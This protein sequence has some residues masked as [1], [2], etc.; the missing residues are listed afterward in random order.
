M[1]LIACVAVNAADFVTEGDGTTYTLESLSTN[2]ESGVTK[3]GP[4]YV[5]ANN[6]TIS[7]ND[8]FAIESGATVKMGDGV[9]LRI[10]GSANFEASDRVLFTRNAETDAPKG[11][12]LSDNT[13]VTKFKNID[14]EYCGLR[15][16]GTKGLDAD[17]CTF[18]Y[19]NGKQSSSGALALGTDGAC[20][21][22]TGC[23]F[24]HNTAPAIG[25]GANYT[26]GIRIENCTFTD[27]NNSNTNKPQLN[28]TVGGDNEIVIKGCTLTGAQRT[29]VGGISVS[30]MLSLA[31]DNIVT[32]EDN[33]IRGHRYGITT[34]GLQYVTIKNNTIVDNQYETNAMNGGSGI[35]IYDSNGVQTAIITGNRIEQNLWGITVI[36][37]KEVNIGKTENPAADDYN[38]GHN[39]FKDNGNGGKLYD[40]YNNTA[41]TV[42]AQGNKWNVD[43]QTADQIETVIFHKNDDSKLGEVIYM[44]AMTGSGIKD[45]VTDNNCIQFIDGKIRMQSAGTVLVYTPCGDLAGKFEAVDGSADISSL[46]KGVY[47][48]TIKT[49]QG[50]R[51]IKCIL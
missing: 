7:A 3:S 33:D 20:F 38:P 35:S 40:L 43:Q 24:E 26:C 28:L 6:I 17:N 19:Y 51:T 46:P 37:G 27:N 5:M 50:T 22:V 34:L 10:E 32:I 1:F 14:F 45:A 39:I 4:V 25:G 18:R 47:I 15:N 2:A 49:A 8:R 44:P 30:N 13:A 36:G 31:G 9:Q 21:N 11:I 23:T 12:Y 16:I 42:Y 48:A 29:K 41:L